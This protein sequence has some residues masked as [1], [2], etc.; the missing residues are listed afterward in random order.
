MGIKIGN[1]NKIKNSN[2]IEKFE[3][4]QEKSTDSFWK[5][6]LVNITSEFIWKLLGIIFAGGIVIGGIYILIK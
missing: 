6:V 4:T 5:S 2:F 3:V 1:N